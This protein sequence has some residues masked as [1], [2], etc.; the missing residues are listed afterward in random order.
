MENKIKWKTG[1]PIEPGTYIVTLSNGLIGV[2]DYRYMRFNNGE[3]GL[4]WVGFCR[5]DDKI[6]AW[7]N[8]NDIKPYNDNDNNNDNDILPFEK[9]QDGTIYV[10][11]FKE[12][13]EHDFIFIYNI[14]KRK[15]DVIRYYAVL[16]T[17]R[18]YMS[19]GVFGKKNRIINLRL[20]TD[21]EK[22][23]LF[24]KFYERGYKW[25]EKTKKFKELKRIK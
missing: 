17:Y 19:K 14:S 21:E 7:C 8:L 2:D 10:A 13:E 23:K 11:Q 6:I 3:E 12:L 20:A 1:K 18:I 22:E 24:K 25:N 4:Y 15:E 5:P 9:L 16:S